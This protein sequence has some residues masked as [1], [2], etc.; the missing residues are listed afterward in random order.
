MCIW[1]P[2]EDPG[3][4]PLRS[5]VFGVEQVLSHARLAMRSCTLRRHGIMR[6]FK[7]AERPDSGS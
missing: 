6:F 2:A 4:R 1:T 3:T 7:R 5:R